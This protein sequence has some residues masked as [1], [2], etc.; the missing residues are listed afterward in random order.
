MPFDCPIVQLSF[1]RDIHNDFHSGLGATWLELVTG[2]PEV[3][4]AWFRH[5]ERQGLTAGNCSWQKLQGDFVKANFGGKYKTHQ[6]Y[7]VSKRIFNGLQR[8]L[9]CVPEWRDFFGEF[10][11][12]QSADLQT[13]PCLQNMHSWQKIVTNSL[14][15]SYPLPLLVSLWM[16]G[17]R[18]LAP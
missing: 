1:L 17:C 13:L 3:D 9:K 4:A 8:D 7:D 16:E 18:F 5:A 10:A 12:F 14:L 2:V 6:L 15:P 11:D